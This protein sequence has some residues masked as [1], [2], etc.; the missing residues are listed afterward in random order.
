MTWQVERIVARLRLVS[1]VALLSVYPVFPLILRAGR[2]PRVAQ[3]PP[4]VSG[5]LGVCTLEMGLFASWFG[6][7]WLL[8]KPGCQQLLAPWRGWKSPLCAGMIQG[9]TLWIGVMLL[10]AGAVP[11]LCQHLHVAKDTLETFRPHAERIVHPDV[12][13]SDFRYLLVS[14][15][16]VSFGLAGL[17]EELWRSALL[18]GLRLLWPDFVLSRS[19]TA[20]VV[21]GVAILFG[22]GHWPQGPGGVLLTAALGLAFGFILLRRR[23]LWEVVVAHGVFDALSFVALAFDSAAS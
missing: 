19:A 10:I 1:Y 17:R 21:S 5:L 2:A 8:A 15:T 23:C 22:L 13:R 20:L 7:A 11:V 16:L 3:L 12:L 4:S 9:L 14:T 6:L 18:H